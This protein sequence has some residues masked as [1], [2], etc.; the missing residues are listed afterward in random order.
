MHQALA[1]EGLF[2]YRCIRLFVRLLR[3]ERSATNGF[4]GTV[5]HT[6]TAIRDVCVFDIGA[7][8]V[9]HSDV[10]RAGNK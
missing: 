4:I 6:N 7:R 10:R 3:L 9:E 5:R 8:P 2:T 1:Q